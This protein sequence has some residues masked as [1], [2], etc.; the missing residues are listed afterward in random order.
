MAKEIYNV[1]FFLLFKNIPKPASDLAL[2]EFTL[3]GFVVLPHVRIVLALLSKLQIAN[4]AFPDSRFKFCLTKTVNIS[5]VG[6]L[7]EA[8]HLDEVYP[9]VA[10]PLIHVVILWTVLAILAKA[11]N[12]KGKLEICAFEI[13]STSK[14]VVMPASL[15]CPITWFLH[16][17][18][19]LKLRNSH[20]L[21]FSLL[22]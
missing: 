7:L 5:P 3:K 10:Q 2:A 4:V 16:W 19:F 6:I 18:I 20:W 14:S 8:V 21:H 17:S 9:Q 13:F 11:D 15:Q 12:L 1:F 22:I